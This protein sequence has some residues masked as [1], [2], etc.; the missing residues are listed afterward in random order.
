[1]KALFEEENNFDKISFFL[2]TL[3]NTRTGFKLDNT[4]FV[5]QFYLNMYVTIT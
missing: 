3:N 1:M 4:L 2:K 5:L